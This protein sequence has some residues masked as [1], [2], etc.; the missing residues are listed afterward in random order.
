MV[1]ARELHM[2]YSEIE[3]KI[4]CEMSVPAHCLTPKVFRVWSINAK[5]IRKF[6]ISSKKCVR[7]P[8]HPV[9]FRNY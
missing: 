2:Y 1:Y 6:R 3:H 7:P 8:Q 4:I 5:Y 9:L